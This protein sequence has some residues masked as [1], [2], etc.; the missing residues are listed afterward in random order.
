[1]FKTILD[2]LLKGFLSGQDVETTDLIKADQQVKRLLLNILLLTGGFVLFA[3]GV[4]RLSLGDKFVG[5]IELALCG[6]MVLVYLLTFSRVPFYI[7]SISTMIILMAFDVI[8]IMSDIYIV[9]MLC[10]LLF[11]LVLLTL[12]GTKLGTFFSLVLLVTLVTLRFPYFSAPGFDGLLHWGVVGLF[13]VL[14]LIQ[15][16]NTLGIGYRNNVIDNMTDVLRAERDQITAMKDNL[17]TAILLLSP[18]MEIQPQYSTSLEQ[19]FNE[20]S[21]EGQSLITLLSASIKSKDIKTLEYFFDMVVQRK[22]D[23]EMLEDLNPL[24]QFTFVNRRTLE[25]KTLRCSFASILGKNNEPY[26]LSTIEDITRET[27]LQQQLSE[28]DAKRHAEMS[29][30]YEVIHVNSPVLLD[31]I[32]DAEFEFTH[33]NSVLKA[34]NSSTATQVL[35]DMYHSIHSIKSNAL[36]LGLNTYGEQLHAYEDEIK[37]VRNLEK[38]PTFDDFLHLTFSLESLIKTNDNFKQIIDRITEFSK[39]SIRKDE[40]KVFI[41]IIEENVRR[42]SLAKNKI[43]NFKLTNIDERIIQEGPRRIIKEILMHFIRN[44]VTHGIETP[45]ERLAKGKNEMGNIRLSMS[46]TDNLIRIILLD[47]GQGINFTAVAEHAKKNNLLTTDELTDHTKLLNLLFADNFSTAKIVDLYAGRG[48]GLGLVKRTLN[49]L[50][51]TLK[52]KTKEG[53]GVKWTIDIPFT[54]A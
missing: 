23:S 19:I 50:N 7:I 51:G 31:F 1:M 27:E 13:I 38:E 35:N 53:I 42:T 26:I 3:F 32:E 41:E 43:V 36:I 17:K 20:E 34:D 52:I 29:A 37:N 24:S 21:L 6:L 39:D 9:G 25:E 28:E 15:L 33:I 11:P 30:L 49:E 4:Y 44:S 8:S 16:L 40:T 10:S 18:S 5:L 2:I 46:I 22:F 45:E 48:A 47:D 54:A 12:I 14:L